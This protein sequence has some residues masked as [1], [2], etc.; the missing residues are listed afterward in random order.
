MDSN[1]FSPAVASSTAHSPGCRVAGSQRRAKKCRSG[2]E[3]I[4][5]L[6]GLVSRAKSSSPLYCSPFRLGAA[7]HLYISRFDVARISGQRGAVSSPGRSR[8]AA[9]VSGP[10]SPSYLCARCLF[11]LSARVRISP[12]VF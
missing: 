7:L 5:L 3:K 11:R 10:P 12:R 2:G 6:D 8:D 1:H 4:A 9:D